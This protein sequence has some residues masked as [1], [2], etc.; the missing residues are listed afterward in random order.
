[1]SKQDGSGRQIT[2]APLDDSTATVLHIDLDAFFASVE[3]LDHPELV[4]KPVV[5]GHRGGRS[6]VT[7]AN[8]VARRYGVNSAMP[9]SLALRRCPNA[10]VLEPHF[11]RYRDLSRQVMSIFDDFTPLVERLGID[12]AFLDVAGARL[13]HGSPLQVGNLIRQR[14]EAETGLT[15]S[16]GAAA[17]KFVA[18][19]ASGRAKPNGLLVIPAEDT[20]DFLH[21]LPVGALWGVGAAT[22]QNLTRLGLTTVGDIAN[23]PLSVLRANLGEVGAQRLHDLSWGR[24]PRVVTIER[25]EKSVGHEVTFEHDVTDVHALRS[26]ILRLSDEVAARLRRG[27]LVGRTVVLKLRYADFSTVT[28]SRTLPEPTNVGRRIY[29]EAATSFDALAASGIRVRLIGVRMEQ[30]GE[31]DGLG[32]GLWDPDDD[33]REAELAIDSVSEKFGRGAVKRAS[34]FKPGRE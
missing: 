14:V 31:R 8:Y 15:C 16:V 19:L 29:E 12:E 4:D 32:M 21:P 30:L 7:A 17:T 18:K 10:I 28:R 22:E 6:V 33:W 2:T 11:D 25:E 5:V 1:M 9:M 13:V 3:L 26:E 27:G 24:D 34:L 23:T 20:L